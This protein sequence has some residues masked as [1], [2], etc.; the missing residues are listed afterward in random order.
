MKQR[1][2]HH[3]ALTLA[4]KI[5]EELR[6]F[7]ERIE[8]AGSLRRKKETVGDIEILFIPR[9]EDRQMDMFSTEPMDLAHEELNR[10]LA[11]G[12]V[13]KREGEKGTTSWGPKNKLAQHPSGIGIDF[14]STTAEN[15]W[16]S[17]VIRT[18]GKETNLSLTNGA[19][20]LN[21]HLNAY[22][23]GFTK[24]GKVIPCHS[25]EDV[26]RLAGVRYR[27]PEERE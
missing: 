13:S 15:W 4:E 21:M 22:G 3:T 17:L 26:F 16:V 8:I 14:F 18:G 27:E 10:W 11:T 20:A 9:M 7:C 1:H 23:S 25:E 12:I 6:P 5:V 2:D 19:I 24:L